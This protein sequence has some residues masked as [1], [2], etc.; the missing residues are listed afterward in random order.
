MQW[1]TAT[2]AIMQALKEKN[3]TITYGELARAIGMIPDGWKGH[4]S[5]NQIG[6]LLRCLSVVEDELKIKTPLP[7]ERI[8]QAATGKP[9]AGLY[10][11][12]K[13]VNIKA[14]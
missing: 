4:Y 6:A 1:M 12:N 11:R 8:V 3:E 5:Q 7:Y 9:G 14:A 2:A 10:T 13:I